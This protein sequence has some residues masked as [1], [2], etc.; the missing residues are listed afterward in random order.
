MIGGTGADTFVFE[1]ATVFSNLDVITDFT[2]RQTDELNIHDL[3]V[4][5]TPE[6]SDINNFMSLSVSGGHTTVSID[7]DR[8]GGFYSSA[9]AFKLDGVTGLDVDDLLN[10]G[11]LMV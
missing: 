10:N 3:F 2:T 1:A 7:R 9:S 6:T 5:Y 8:T 11:N 4:G